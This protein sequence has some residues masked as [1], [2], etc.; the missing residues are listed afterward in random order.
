M[1]I[2]LG[3]CVTVKNGSLFVWAYV[4]LLK[5]SFVHVGH[6]PNLLQASGELNKEDCD[7]HYPDLW[8]AVENIIYTES[9]VDNGI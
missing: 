4:T 6:N 3:V 9:E 5:V 8:Q 1:L 2:E 7:K